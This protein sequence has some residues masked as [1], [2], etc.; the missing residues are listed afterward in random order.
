[1]QYIHEK[2]SNYRNRDKSKLAG[3]FTKV[4]ELYLMINLD[5][6]MFSY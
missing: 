4:I 2:K 5:I 1:M 6:I 3:T